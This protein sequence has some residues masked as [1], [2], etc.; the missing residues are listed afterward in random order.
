MEE[1]GT[2]C[3]LAMLLGDVYTKIDSQ[4]QSGQWDVSIMK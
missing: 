2:V 3:Y 1:G 4:S